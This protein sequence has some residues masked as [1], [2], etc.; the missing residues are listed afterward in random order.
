M[1]EGSPGFHGHTQ[2]ELLQ[3]ALL[4]VIFNAL[5][6]KHEVQNMVLQRPNINLLLLSRNH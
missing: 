4:H 3:R 6:L 1:D 5:L 2:K